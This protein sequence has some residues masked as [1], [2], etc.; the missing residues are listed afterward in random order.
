MAG[1]TWIDGVRQPAAIAASAPEGYDWDHAYDFEQNCNDSVG[2]L[3]GT[4]SGGCSYEDNG[5]G[6]T[7][8]RVPS[9]NSVT[10]LSDEMLLLYSF[11]L[12][13]RMR[14]SAGSLDAPLLYK[15]PDPYAYTTGTKNIYVT[16]AGALN[17]LRH[18][19]G[20]LGPIGMTGLR[21]GTWKTIEIIVGP[22]TSLFLLN[23]LLMY[24]YGQ[25][26]SSGANAH[27]VQI[28]YP[29]AA[30]DSIDIDYLLYKQISTS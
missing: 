29:L 21:D 20:V 15:G 7:C 10:F 4:P 25:T 27:P 3:H 12:K 2:T 23:G 22:G 8:I 17:V 16:N 11:R 19:S 24:Y 28:G 14:A 18:S 6:G 30:R 9:L 1:D 5:E 13:M 26:M